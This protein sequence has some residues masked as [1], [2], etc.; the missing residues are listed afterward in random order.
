MTV[1]T[2]NPDS[3]VRVSIIIPVYNE[4]RSVEEVLRRVIDAPLPVGCEKEIVVVDDGS[5]DG[6][7][8]LLKKLHDQKLI[9]FHTTI[10]NFGKGAALRVGFRLA[11]GNIILV[12]DGDLEYDP[13]DYARLLQP[14]LDGS[15]KVVYGS[16]FRGTL[17]GMARA[18]WLANKVLTFLANLLYRAQITDEAT[19][20]KAFRREVLERIELR[21]KHFE[22]CPEVTAKVRRL[23]IPIAEVPISYHGRTASEGKKIRWRDGFEAVWTLLRYRF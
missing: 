13:R 22:F 7:T 17:T 10:V 11:T 12:Q 2:A 16:R 18:N 9:R 14:L 15:A 1:R 23:G 3:P 5:T 4:I 21:C 8:A 20:Y 6:T 19:A